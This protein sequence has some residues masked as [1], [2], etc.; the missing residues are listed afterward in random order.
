M[1][2]GDL[3]VERV[4]VQELLF[5]PSNVRAHSRRN[6]DSIKSSLTRFG[7]QKPIIVD[8]DNVVRAG[9]GTLEA[10]KEL[11][12]E[13]IS[14]V[15]SELIGSE[16][17]AFAIADNRTAELAEW[18][19][20]QLGAVLG[21]LREEGEE[22]SESLGFTAAEIEALMPQGVGVDPDAAPDEADQS[23]GENLADELPEASQVCPS[24]GY[25]F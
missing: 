13:I 7:Q 22:V 25:R 2:Q 18:D 16:M 20:S 4:A 8:R 21:S 9:N 10:A 12:W 14:V 1:T 3:Q 17:T 5:D 15:R 19:Y 11:G 24:C 23:V 6:L